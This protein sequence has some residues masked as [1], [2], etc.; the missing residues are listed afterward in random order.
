MSAPSSPVR[1][2]LIED[3]DPDVLLI[4][5]ALH[6]EAIPF[7]L[8]RFEDGEIA[9]EAFERPAEDGPDLIILD[10]N[11]PKVSGLEL[12]PAIRANPDY[13]PV[14]VMILTSSH[15]P[16]DRQQAMELGATSYVTKPIALDDF[17]RVVGGAVHAL[18]PRHP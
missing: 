16:Y 12:L 7:H 11:L 18:L 17:L 15:S 2:T 6:H 5:E 3:N 14:P 8:T 13:A 9:R 1:I 4:R 10:L